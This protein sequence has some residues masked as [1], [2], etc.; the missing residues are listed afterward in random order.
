MGGLLAARLGGAVRVTLLAPTP[1]GTPLEIRE[2]SDGSLGLWQGGRLRVRARREPLELS[3]PPAP[4]RETTHAQTGTCRAFL[5]HP[6]P[7]CFV[8]G[9][10]RAPGDGLRIFPGPV[11]GSRAAAA[12]WTPAPDLAS[13]G[14]FAPPEIVWA[15]LDSSS[16][17]PLLETP[18]SQALEPLVLAGLHAEIREPVVSGQA[19]LLQMWPLGFEGRRGTAGIALYGPDDQVRA[20]GIA[21]WVSL[22]GRA[23]A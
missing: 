22:A 9:P 12:H 8:C 4:D 17:F 15:A 21:Q 20:A 19:H 7:G 16:A 10:D 5:T 11:P 18:A 6:F 1:L 13:R 14:A 2:E 3:L 23:G